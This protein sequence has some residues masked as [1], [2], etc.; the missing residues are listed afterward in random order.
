MGI[1]HQSCVIQMKFSIFI[2][3]FLIHS[4]TQHFRQ[5]HIVAAQRDHLG[6]LTFQIYRTF[7]DSRRTD[8]LGWKGR[9]M[10]LRKFIHIPSRAHTTEIR[11]VSQITGDQID[12]EF[13]CLF[14]DIIGIPLF[15]YGNGYHGRAGTDSSCPCHCDNIRSFLRSAAAYHH[16]RNRIEHIAASPVLFSHHIFLPFLI[17]L[18]SVEK[19][20][21]SLGGESFD[22]NHRTDQS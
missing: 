7:R 6:N 13:S 12:D 16:S 20:P 22:L 21:T 5:K 14:Q 4:H 10:H 11:S 1:C 3:I 17:C 8:V 15:P 19:T 9:Q 18:I 2:H